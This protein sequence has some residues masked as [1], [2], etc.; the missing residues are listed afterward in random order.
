MVSTLSRD[1]RTLSSTLTSLRM[2]Q[3]QAFGSLNRVDS[4]SNYY[5]EVNVASKC[6]LEE[7]VIESTELAQDTEG[8]GQY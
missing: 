2:L 8:E 3:P 5:I 4:A 1:P 7:V 6:E